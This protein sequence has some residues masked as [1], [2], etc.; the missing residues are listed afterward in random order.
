MDVQYIPR[1]SNQYMNL[2]NA[3]CVKQMTWEWLL[4]T[5]APRTQTRK[6]LIQY[7]LKNSKLVGTITAG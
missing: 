3:V 5:A 6:F 2:L 4:P 7:L 1:R